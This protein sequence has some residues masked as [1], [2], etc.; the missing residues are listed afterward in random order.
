MPIRYNA[1]VDA[2][3]LCGMRVQRRYAVRTQQRIKAPL[4]IT[5]QKM[6]SVRYA[7]DAAS[8]ASDARA[9]AYARAVVDYCHFP[10]LL[11]FCPRH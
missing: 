7:L 9:G 10:P 1:Y 5:M 8:S 4:Y 6:R 11:P 3:T 2:I